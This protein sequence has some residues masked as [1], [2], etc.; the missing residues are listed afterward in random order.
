M[1]LIR[2]ISTT[3]PVPTRA[4]CGSTRAPSG[5]LWFLLVTPALRGASRG[6]PLLNALASLPI[7]SAPRAVEPRRLP[8]R[9]PATPAEGQF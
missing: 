6:R 9:P 4:T 2:R 3:S 5:W 7:F 1:W 8:F